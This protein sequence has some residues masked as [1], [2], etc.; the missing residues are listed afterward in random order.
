MWGQ[1]HCKSSTEAFCPRTDYYPCSGLLI[2][3]KCLSSVVPVLCGILNSKFCVPKSWYL[4]TFRLSKIS[5]FEIGN[6]I[7]TRLLVSTQVSSNL[8]TLW[9]FLSYKLS[10]MILKGVC[11][12]LSRRD[13]SGILI[14]STFWTLNNVIS[15]NI[16]PFWLLL[17]LEVLFLP[18]THLSFC[19]SFSP[20]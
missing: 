20:W 5:P 17:L 13:F 6:A 19:P 11:Y 14:S 9:H 2:H 3:W 10:S 15:L 16:F 7:Y 8:E 12:S 4:V 18:S 1:T